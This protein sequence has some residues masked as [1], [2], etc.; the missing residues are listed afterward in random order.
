MYFLKFILDISK[1]GLVG[2]NSEISDEFENLT[3]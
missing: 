1:Q 3:C 2:V